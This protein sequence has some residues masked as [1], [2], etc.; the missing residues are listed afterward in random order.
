[1]PNPGF[2]KYIHSRAPVNDER[3][4]SNSPQGGPS[5]PPEGLLSVPEV[6][7]DAAPGESEPARQENRPRSGSVRILRNR[8]GS[9]EHLPQAVP[10]S[11]IASRRGRSNTVGAPEVLTLDSVPLPSTAHLQPSPA[12][13]PSTSLSVPQSQSFLG[14]MRSG[15]EPPRSV[16]LI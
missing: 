10:T 15:S 2:S 7:I 13:E 4:M 9:S 3:R 14:R 6:Q 5:Q 1:M 11:T 8:P 12:P 16:H